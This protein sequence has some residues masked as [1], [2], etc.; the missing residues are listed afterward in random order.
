MRFFCSGE[1]REV[2]G[3]VWRSLL[4]PKPPEG[5]RCDGCS[6]S[7]DRLFGV[8]IWPAC[9]IHDYH[10]REGVIGGTWHARRAADRILRANIRDQFNRAGK[11][12]RGRLVARLYY[13]RVRIWGAKAFK[14]AE[15][16]KPRHIFQRLR[17]V[18]G[19]W[20]PRQ[21]AIDETARNIRFGRR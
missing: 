10:Y 20:S 12:R 1:A 6:S 17:E 3:L 13:G 19:R 5:Y 9:V 18:Y 14:F 16:E 2:P 11:P 21:D 4:G 8:D 7:P 15:D